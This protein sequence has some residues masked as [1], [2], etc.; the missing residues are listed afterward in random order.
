M[1]FVS[2]VTIDP[3]GPLF[4]PISIQKNITCL[5]DQLSS[6][7]VLKNNVEVLYVLAVGSE[8]VEGIMITSVNRTRVL[9]S[10]NTNNTSLSGLRCEGNIVNKSGA[11]PSSVILNLT[12]YGKW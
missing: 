12:I 4:L 1:C 8:F 10:V 9:I 2:V 11:F 3:P 6:L 5:G 7:Y